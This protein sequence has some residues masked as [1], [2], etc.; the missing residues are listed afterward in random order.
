MGEFVAIDGHPT[1]V[2]DTGTGT[3]VLVLHGGF[4]NSDGLVEV[5]APLAADYR[6][7]AFDRRGHG[8]TADTDA[9]F[10]YADM[11]TETAGV[12]A[13]A[14][15]EAAHIVG[16]SD[17]GIIALL[18]ALARP[19]LV[20]SL[21]LIGTNYHYDGVVPGTFED[22]GHDSDS[23]AFLQPGYAERSPD[24]GDHFAVVVAK[25]VAMLTT[26][27]TLTTD[28]LARIPMPALV[29]AG[30]DDMVEPAHTQ[31]LYESLPNG[32]LAVVPGASHVVPYE[33]PA[34]VA[35]LVAEFLGS[36]GEVATMMPV[37]RA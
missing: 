18:L 3:P 35:Q 36:G 8:R 6:V 34:L 21:V 30:D 23:F 19:D 10:H 5:F 27:P 12:L 31:S 11:T 26:E 28:D 15:G 1:W 13:H 29:M 33:K 32:Q 14:G 25:G 7:I 2:E 9:P 37:R 4:S 16:Y 17:G 22:F 20:R 24:G